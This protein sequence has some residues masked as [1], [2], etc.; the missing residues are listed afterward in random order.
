LE[1]LKSELSDGQSKPV[2]EL[3]HKAR[4]NRI[5]V[6]SL[7]AS[8]KL[9]GVKVTREGGQTGNFFWSLPE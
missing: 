4:A 7:T 1:F 9:L 2:V 3:Q 5:P 6:R 8:R